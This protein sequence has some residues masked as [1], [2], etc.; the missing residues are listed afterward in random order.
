[1][2]GWLVVEGG[3]SVCVDVVPFIAELAK[4]KKLKEIIFRSLKYGLYWFNLQNLFA[5][6]TSLV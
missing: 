4:W 6:N 2:R 3:V 5:L 1:M